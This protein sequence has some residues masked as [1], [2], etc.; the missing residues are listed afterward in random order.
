M[1]EKRPWYKRAWVILGLVFVSV[2]LIGMVLFI[3]QT[4]FFYSG[5]KQGKSFD[6]LMSVKR[7][8]QAQ[9]SV[10]QENPET[11]SRIKKL[12]AGKSGEPYQGSASSVHEIVEFADFGCPY[13]KTSEATVRSLA[14]NRPDIRVSFRDFPVT[15]LHP[16]AE[17]AAQAARC[18]WLQGRPS[19]YWLYRDALYS[20]QERLDALG[21]RDV[22]VQSGVDLGDYDACVRN[23]ETAK[24]VR[25]SLSDAEQAGV[26]GTPTYFVDGKMLEGDV[27]LDKLIEALD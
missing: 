21:L 12:V 7:T 13:S 24:G 3:R 15:E 10:V 26:R 18:V 20:N 9:K 22:A 17:V 14:R 23:G 27:P 6:D 4:V 2:T 1:E 11:K 16:Y 25:Q 19:V 5:L 8:A